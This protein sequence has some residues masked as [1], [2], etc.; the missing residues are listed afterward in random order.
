M[1]RDTTAS[2]TDNPTQQPTR[3]APRGRIRRRAKSRK[4]LSKE[5][6]AL[7][8]SV[9]T[10]QAARLL[11]YSRDT[12]L[13]FRKCGGGPRYFK[14]TNSKQGT[15]RYRVADLLEWMQSKTIANTSDGVQANG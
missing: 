13:R 4:P 1:M 2:P 15:V 3:T 10:D 7:L 9:D 6:Q 8:E 12:L 5:A 14:S 11:G